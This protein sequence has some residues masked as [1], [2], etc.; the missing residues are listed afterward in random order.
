MMM[1]MMIQMTFTM[2]TM[3]TKGLNDLKGLK[4]HL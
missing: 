3:T 2:K 1:I 4:D